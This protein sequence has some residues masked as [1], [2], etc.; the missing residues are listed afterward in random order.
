MGSPPDIL[1]MNSLTL[2][3][4]LAT[5]TLSTGQAPSEDCWYGSFCPYNRDSQNQFLIPSTEDTM[6][7]K[8]TWCQ[9]KCFEDT[10]TCAHFTIHTAR[11]GTQCYLL[12]SCND[13]SDN[14]ACIKDGLCNSGPKNCADNNNCDVLPEYT[15]PTSANKINWQCD[16]SINPYTQQVPE[17]E[18]CFLSC[19]A[20]VD[21]VTG[22][23]AVI[24]S[25]CETGA[26]TTAAVSPAGLTIPALPATIPQPDGVE[27]DQV[28]CSCAIQP[29]AW[30]DV[31]DYD[32][33][34]LPGTDFICTEEYVDKTTDPAD[35]KFNLVPT[36]VCRLFCDSY[37]ITT[38]ACENGVWTGEPELGAWCYYEPVAADDMNAE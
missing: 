38:M 26:W 29:M 33:N 37:H 28:A 6:L 19:N 21:S 22:T 14:D 32:P 16:G 35:W 9:L 23:P 24:T 4:L 8:M 17:G 12:D 34:T 30:N 10:G 13:P 3:S 25:K 18:T 11:G 15:D 1:T 31:I 5:V 2:L 27:A 36:N 7:K 20:W